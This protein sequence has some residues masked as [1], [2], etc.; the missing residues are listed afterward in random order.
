[1]RFD[2]EGL[3]VVDSMSSWL[4]TQGIH[5]APTAADHKLGLVGVHG[6][7]VKDSSRS[8][9]CESLLSAGGR[10]CLCVDEQVVPEEYIGHCISDDV[11]WR[12]GP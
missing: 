11:R 12:A 4:E 6:R 7:I 10:R 8:V 5:L 1:M 9:V 2:R 3:V